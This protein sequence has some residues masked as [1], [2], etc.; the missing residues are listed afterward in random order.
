[1]TVGGRLVLSCSVRLD[2]GV[3]ANAGREVFGRQLWVP[4][5]IFWFGLGSLTTGQMFGCPYGPNSNVSTFYWG[6][7]TIID[8]TRP[9]FHP[10]TRSK[11][12]GDHLQG[13]FTENSA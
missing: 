8:T 7:V 1:M 3:D 12:C 9:K 4:R 5:A 10:E 13:K 6:L 11:S 2:A